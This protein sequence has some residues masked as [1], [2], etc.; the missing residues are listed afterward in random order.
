MTT[1]ADE[2]LGNRQR[3]DETAAHRLHIEGGR[4]MIAQLALQQARGTRKDEIRGRGGDN[5]QVQVGSHPDRQQVA[6]A[7]SL[8]GPD[9]W[10]LAVFATR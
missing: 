5:D 4:A 3:I 8:R 9:R 2:F 1:R 6:L 7:G 10:R